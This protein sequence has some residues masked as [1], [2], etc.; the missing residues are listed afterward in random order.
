MFVDK[1][2]VKFVAG[3][4]GNGLVSWRREKFIARGGPDGG[5][6]GDGGD[7]IVEGSSSE[8]TLVDFR[9]KKEISAEHGQNGAKRKKHGRR[10]KDL[11][12]KLPVGTVITNEKPQTLTDI[13][14]VGQRHII[15]KG[16][17]GGFGNAHFV[18]SRRQAPKIA[19]LGEPGEALNL[20]L[21]LKMI[22]DVG[23]VGL[24]NAGKST[25][26]SK[27]SNARPEIADYPFTT[28]RPHL[29]VVDISDSSILLAD[30]PG[31]IE[32]ASKGKG[33]GDE[34]LRHVERTKV[35]IH[36]IDAYQEDIV[37]AYQTIISELKA[38][39]VDLSKR[40]QIV[41]INKTDN[42]P[43]DMISDITK[44]LKRSMPKKD[45]LFTISALSGE[46]LKQLMLAAYDE[47]V[48]SRKKPA[49]A[50]QSEKDIPIL[51]LKA[52][53][54]NWKVIKRDK[55]FIVSGPKI[56]RFA[57]RTDFSNSAGVERLR[58]IMRKIGIMHELERRKI[59]PNDEI[60]I[61]QN[62]NHT[63]KY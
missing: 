27:V 51:R 9:Y 63:I 36:V 11:I 54:D 2:E 41:A 19:E 6:G 43:Q 24:P 31:L 50:K 16:G 40:P 37:G 3:K 4:G 8:N 1:V 14:E 55:K 23:L 20:T 49:N 32:G 38:Y 17:K 48:K 10:G 30:I 18:S 61:G 12:I 22:A 42:M 53:D 60:Q 21:E 45:K 56:E 13:T 39:K 44:K 62:T 35:L 52:T 57:V 47:V 25:L 34:F 5:D 46:G 15:A 29:G 58:D 33:L 28:L 59:N 7:I 26:L